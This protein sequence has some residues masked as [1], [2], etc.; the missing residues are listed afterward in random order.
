MSMKHTPIRCSSCD[1]VSRLVHR[2]I[3]LVYQLPGGQEFK[4]ERRFCWCNTCGEIRDSEPDFSAYLEVDSRI[5]DL[6]KTMSSLGAK[7]YNAIDRLLGG[8]AMSNDEQ[9]LSKLILGRKIARARSSESRCLDCGETDIQ[10]L[11]EYIHNCGGHLIREAPPSEASRFNYAPVTIYLDFEGRTLSNPIDPYIQLAQTA[12]IECVMKKS[13]FALLYVSVMFDEEDFAHL[14]RDTEK[15]RKFAKI[16]ELRIMHEDFINPL[17][18]FTEPPT[19]AQMASIREATRAL[20]VR[21]E[22]PISKWLHSQIMT[23]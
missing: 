1:Y 9:E 20:I 23:R 7:A 14:L 11:D 10:N 16:I 4:T 13:M 21:N 12:E 17:A 19:E 18:G 3:T 8:R 5:D 15:F 2:P 22:K 6:N